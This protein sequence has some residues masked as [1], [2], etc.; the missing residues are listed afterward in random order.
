MT[1]CI[2]IW[3]FGTFTLYV[4]QNMETALSW[5]KLYDLGVILIPLAFLYF[6][7]AISDDES[8]AGKVV[9]GVACVLSAIFILCVNLGYFNPA[10]YRHPWGFYPTRGPANL[11]F[12]AYFALALVLSGIRLTA[13][14][15]VSKGWQRNQFR[16]I[17]LATAIGFGSGVTNFLPLYGGKVY[18]VGHIGILITGTII[19]IA[20]IRYRL[21]DISLIIRNSAVYSVLTAIVTA[22]YVAIVFVLQSVFRGITGSNSILAVVIVSLIVAMTFEPIRGKVQVVIDRLFFRENFEFQKITKEAGEALRT[23]V[24][25]GRISYHVLN[26][27][28]DVIKICNGLVLVLTGQPIHLWS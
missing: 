7:L 27:I 16:Y 14:Y 11:P 21:M 9:L 22:A 25:P 26:A 5:L 4:S 24:S 12:D 8:R 28:V 20:I 23:E 1:L 13:A 15:R 19:T 3:S 2:A 18:P 17:F 6:T 10:L